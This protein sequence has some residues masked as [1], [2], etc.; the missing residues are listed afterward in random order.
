MS[1]DRNYDPSPLVPLRNCT[2][3]FQ[4]Q[5]AQRV[6]APPPPQSIAES[7]RACQMFEK[8][9]SDRVIP[10]SQG[11]RDLSSTALP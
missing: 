5:M 8:K 10:R 4:M 9:L 2:R 11:L 6:D 3:A 1:S 7:F